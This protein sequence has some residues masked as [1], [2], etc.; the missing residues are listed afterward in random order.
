M[1]DFI[2][3]IKKILIDKNLQL[4]QLA[5]MLD[6]SPSMLSQYM[7]KKDYRINADILRIADALGLDVTLTLTDQETGQTYDMTP[8]RG[9]GA[10]PHI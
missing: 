10:Q 7:R 6:M 5:E 2:R 9:R 3:G 1:I 8:T 4:A